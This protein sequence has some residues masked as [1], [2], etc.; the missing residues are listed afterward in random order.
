MALVDVVQKVIQLHHLCLHSTRRERACLE[1]ICEEL[2]DIPQVELLSLQL[3]AELD[4]LDLEL[5]AKVLV[6]ER[7][8]SGQ[9][10]TW[11]CN[12]SHIEVT[13][14]YRT[15]LPSFDFK[16]PITSSFSTSSRS[17]PS[18]GAGVSP[19]FLSSFLG[20]IFNCVDL[21]TV[22]RLAALAMSLPK[23]GRK[24][25]R[26]SPHTQLPHPEVNTVSQHDASRQKRIIPRQ[27][28]SSCE[29]AVA[30]NC[31]ASGQ[32]TASADD[33]GGWVMRLS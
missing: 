29:S 27:C 14:K 9:L 12:I 23:C 8:R 21:L 3:V 10:D 20:G 31:H 1:L 4:I 11:H 15:H 13:S 2:I 6:P 5:V 25:Y 24:Q 7:G 32:V 17:A 30:P 33:E 28:P 18:S 16:Y 22:P 26:R 19:P